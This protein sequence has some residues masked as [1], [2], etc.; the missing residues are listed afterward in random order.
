MRRGQPA[1]AMS[2]AQ[3]RTPHGLSHPEG[4]QWASLRHSLTHSLFSLTHCPNIACPHLSPSLHSSVWTAAGPG[5][6]P[7]HR[8]DTSWPPMVPCQSGVLS[9]FFLQHSTRILD[10]GTLPSAR[11]PPCR[12]HRETE[13]T[14]EAHCSLKGLHPTAPRSIRCP[15][16]L[17]CLPQRPSLACPSCTCTP[18]RPP[19]P[20][21]TPSFPPA[22]AMAP[23]AEGS[24][25]GDVMCS[26]K[27]KPSPPAPVR[28]TVHSPYQNA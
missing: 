15:Q 21:S 2:P 27:G 11:A 13:G 3:K 20:R 23:A 17:L 4:P 19:A 8:V 26:A 10:T 14:G 28:T 9:L 6:V 7:W 1:A 16:A 18:R 25:G 22:S 5:C 12:P 24:L